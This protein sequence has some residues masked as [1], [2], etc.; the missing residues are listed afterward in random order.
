M[1]FKLLDCIRY[2]GPA[3]IELAVCHNAGT[4][5]EAE[6][7]RTTRIPDREACGEALPCTAAETSATLKPVVKAVIT[8]A[9]ACL[10]FDCQQERAGAQPG[11]KMNCIN[12]HGILNGDIHNRDDIQESNTVLRL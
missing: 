2:I 12:M 8:A 3:T 7:L 1:V 10:T 11:S 6:W 4:P 9:A 5:L